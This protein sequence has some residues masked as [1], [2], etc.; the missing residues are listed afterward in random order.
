MLLRPCAPFELPPR[1][2]WQAEPFRFSV[3]P[4]V[5][6]DTECPSGYCSDETDIGTDPEQ[7]VTS[8]WHHRAM[9][10]DRKRVLYAEQDAYVS[11]DDGGNSEGG[12]P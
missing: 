12:E 4:V 3:E 10:G 5:V 9:L 11:G 8:S 1:N 7:V 2:A 6:V